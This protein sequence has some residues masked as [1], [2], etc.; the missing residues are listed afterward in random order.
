MRIITL[1]AALLVSAAAQAVELHVNDPWVRTAPPKAPARVGYMQIHNPTNDVVTL[2]GV[3]SPQFAKVEIHR[4]SIT[5]GMMR[6]EHM[7]KL[8]I[9]AAGEVRLEPNGYHLMLRGNQ[10]PLATGAEVTFDL[11]WG[12]G[13]TQRVIAKVRPTEDKAS[14]EHSHEGQPHHDH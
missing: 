14:G 7:D 5:E 3:T 6:M 4:T 9:P 10:L 8:E 13:S 11:Q 2:V 1:L 12:D